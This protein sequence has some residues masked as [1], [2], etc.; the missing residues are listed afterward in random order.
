MCVL[1]CFIINSYLIDLDNTVYFSDEP[2][3]GEK[4]DCASEQEK[5]ECHDESVAEVEECRGSTLEIEL[6]C[7]VMN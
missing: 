5:E 4:S 6:G 2:E 3:A 1:S 7:I